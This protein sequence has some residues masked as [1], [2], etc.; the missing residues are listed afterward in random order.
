MFV[1]S[2]QSQGVYRRLSMSLLVAFVIST[3]FSTLVHAL[4]MNMGHDFD[5]EFESMSVSVEFQDDH[6][7]GHSH[8]DWDDEVPSTHEHDHNPIDHSHEIPAVFLI[9]GGALPVPEGNVVS[10][11][12][13]PYLSHVLNDLDRP[14]RM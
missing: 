5:A 2:I 12:G 7:H 13:E 3:F 10:P 8:D 9:S 4:P 14:P 1:S 11:H 6:N